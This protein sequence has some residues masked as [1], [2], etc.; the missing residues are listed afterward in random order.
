MFI[1]KIYSGVG[2]YKYLI[3]SSVTF[4]PLYLWL[5]S[6]LFQCKLTWARLIQ[7]SLLSLLVAFFV[8]KNTRLGH[9]FIFLHVPLI[10]ALMIFAGTSQATNRRVLAVLAANAAVVMLLA[11]L[12]PLQ[13]HSDRSRDAVLQYLK[14]R[15]NVEETLINFSSWGGYYIL[16][17][18][19]SPSQLVTTTEPL[20]V[21]FGRNLEELANESGR[22]KILNVCYECASKSWPCYK[23]DMATMKETFPNTNIVQIGFNQK[24]TWKIFEISPVD[25]KSFCTQSAATPPGPRRAPVG[26][27]R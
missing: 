8:M 21:S 4:A 1:S 6:R 24:G 11:Q 18:Y 2:E 23:C 12:L 27:R 13:G 25:G 15:K 26:A 16:E 14:E 9:H 19:G 17:L 22:R 10:I 5:L 20:D 3:I 7:F